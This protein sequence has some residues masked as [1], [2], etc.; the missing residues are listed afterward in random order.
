MGNASEA[1]HRGR[2]DSDPR[3]QNDCI[4]NL[5]TV[6]K[7][8]WDYQDTMPLDIVAFALE[9]TITSSKIRILLARMVRFGLM[10]LDE[11]DLKAI[12]S[13]LCS[14]VLF[15]ILLEVQRTNESGVADLTRNVC[16]CFHSHEDADTARY[17]GTL[18]RRTSFIGIED[19]FSTVS[20]S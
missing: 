20:M 15:E 17:C 13:K 3:P 6:W 14:E 19:L 11:E 9:H 5:V 7:R 12:K 8:R 4:N 2:E 18:R 10:Q 16:Y 1:V